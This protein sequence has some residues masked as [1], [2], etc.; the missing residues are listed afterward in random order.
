LSVSTGNSKTSIEI[1]ALKK[2]MV[3]VP[4]LKDRNLTDFSKCDYNSFRTSKWAQQV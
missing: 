2:H 3:N 4:E 1:F